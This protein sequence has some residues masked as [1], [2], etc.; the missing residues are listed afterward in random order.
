M[1]IRSS[2]VVAAVVLGL[3]GAVPASAAPIV[4]TDQAAF[5][6]AVSNVGVDTFD[7]LGVNNLGVN[8]LNRSAGPYTYSA[9]VDLSTFWGLDSAGD[10]W[11]S[12]EQA[13]GVVT[14]DSF[15]PEVQ[16][17]GA[18]FFATTQAGG[19]ISWPVTV[20]ANDASGGTT[21]VTLS[22]LLPTTFLGFVS[23]GALTSV[24][25]ATSDGGFW[26]TV[27]D[28]HLASAPVD[29]NVPEPASVA[30]FAT[31]LLAAGVWRRRK[32]HV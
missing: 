15:S 32:R 4:Y 23:D 29:A 9:S 21:T 5:L 6:A 3:L 24:T 14:F 27:N 2:C 12:T 26:P 11:L 7:D 1:S 19:V 10:T 25:V 13:G 22:D 30:L 31:G 16:G 28:L 20:T 8:S 18:F 17:F